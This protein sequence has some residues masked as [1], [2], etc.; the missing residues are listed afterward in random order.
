MLTNLSF[1]DTGKPWPPPQEEKRLERYAA[2][3]KLF[4]GEH[5]EVYRQQLARIQREVGAFEDII[6]YVVVPNYQRLIS[7]KT[8]DLLAGEPPEITIGTG[9]KKKSLTDMFAGALSG[10]DLQQTIYQAAI[11]IS[12]YGDALLKVEKD[13]GR[14]VSIGAAQPANWFPVV[15]GVNTKRF[16]YHVVAW[17]EDGPDGEDESRRLHVQVHARGSYTYTVYAL[18][19]GTIGAVV[20]PARKYS[21]GLSGFAVFPLQGLMTSDSVYGYDDYTPID[22][23]ASEIMVV[24]GNISRILDK[25]AAPSMQGPGQVL[26]D[27]GKGGYR[28]PTGN[29]FLR[30]SNEEPPIEYITWDGQLSA[31]FAHL[32]NL[33]EQLYVISEMG[34]A[35]LGTNTHQGVTTYKGLKLRMTAALSKVRRISAG[36]TAQVKAAIC[37]AL[38][39]EGAGTAQP[40]EIS[41]WWNDG[42][43]DDPLEAMQLIQLENGGL[44]TMSH[45]RSIKIAGKMTDEQAAAEYADILE[46]QARAMPAVQLPPEEDDAE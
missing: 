45:E 6:G 24:I 32:K 23:I 28:L 16:L 15:D 25:H 13:K 10:T 35:I 7:V 4:E 40:S 9:D 30:N 26:D 34:E 36:I 8:A 46:D 43:P 20:Q 11:D 31:A 21:T 3:R 33:L 19:K 37:A 5:G 17:A 1:L 18:G 2:H 38:Q 29:Y 12:R 27:D 41:I 39:L 42:I 14:G 22:S 44:P